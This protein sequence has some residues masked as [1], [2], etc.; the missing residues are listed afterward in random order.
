MRASILVIALIA[1]VVASVAVVPSVG[2]CHP[3]QIGGPY[4]PPNAQY[5]PLPN[6]DTVVVGA[7]VTFEG[8]PHEPTPVACAFLVRDGRPVAGGCA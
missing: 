8:C 3:Q 2:A 6:G 1:P 5:V 4:P 7:G